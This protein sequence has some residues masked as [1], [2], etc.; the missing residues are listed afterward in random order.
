MRQ[1]KTDISF[2]RI[3]ANGKCRACTGCFQAV[4]GIGDVNDFVSFQNGRICT[5]QQTCCG[6]KYGGDPF[7]SIQISPYMEEIV[8]Q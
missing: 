3:I 4:F 7:F 6:H 1:V 8:I 5:E 2:F